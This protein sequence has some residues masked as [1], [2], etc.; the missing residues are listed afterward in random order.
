MDDVLTRQPI[1]DKM[2]KIQSLRQAEKDGKPANSEE[3]AGDPSVNVADVAMES[4]DEQDGTGKAGISI[5]KIT[6]DG[7]NLAE[8]VRFARNTS[9]RSVRLQ[10]DP[11]GPGELAALLKG[12][13]IA[14]IS[15]PYLLVLYD[16][17]RAGESSSR[18]HLR[19]PPLRDAHLQRTI[20]GTLMGF[21]DGDTTFAEHLAFFMVDKSMGNASAIS[22]VFT[23]DKGR[24]MKK[25]KTQMYLQTTEAERQIKTRVKGVGTV[26]TLQL[27]TV[28]T[29]KPMDLVAKDH[30]HVPGSNCADLL[31]PFERLNPESLWKVR[32]KEKGTLY[33]KA[34]VQVGGAVEGD[35]GP[36]VDPGP[37]GNDLVPF[38][39]HS[40]P[41]EFYEELVHSYE[42]SGIIDL[43]CTDVVAPLACVKLRKPYW[44]LCHT[45]EHRDALQEALVN[46][47]FRAM[48][49]PSDKLYEP[50]L[51]DALPESARLP[52][53]KPKP[54]KKKKNK[55]QPKK[56]D[57]DL[58]EPEEDSASASKL[59]DMLRGM[60]SK[61]NKK[62]PKE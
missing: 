28:F 17:G 46:A 44:G 22:K 58:G 30:L 8:W 16:T 52:E 3:A 33:G 32:H 11:A 12:D 41:P 37:K 47:I 2:E 61:E 6:D 55:K 51:L 20:R 38:S 50:T 35:P 23:D 53:A 60:E 40:L 4:D 25:Y 34:M 62:D 9:A 49:N 48:Q 14:Q 43:T 15:D 7:G 18:P 31:G 39:W 5:K 24:V 29:A 27:M 10:V 21:S 26:S 54:E 57:E 1:C 19:P 59:L 56:D 13:A 42:G 45:Q 36:E